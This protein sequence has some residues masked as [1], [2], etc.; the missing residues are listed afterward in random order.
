[1]RS[2]VALTLALVV[3]GAAPASRTTSGCFDGAVVS[4]RNGATLERFHARERGLIRGY[5]RTGPLLPGEDAVADGHGGWYVAGL[6]LAHLRGNGS[7]DRTWHSPLRRRLQL[8]TLARSGDRLFVS[9]GRRVFAVDAERGRIVWTSVEAGGKKAWSIRALVATGDAVYI[10]GSFSRIGSA[11]RHQLAA[12]SASNG[13]LLPWQAP[14]LTPYGP[15]IFPAVDA[16]AAGGG[17]LYFAGASGFRGVG[18]T[19]RPDGV[20]AVRLSDGGLT[21]FQPRPTVEPLSLAVAGRNVL[22]GSQETGGG[23]YDTRTGRLRPKIGYVGGA[24]AIAVRGSY[25]YVGGNFRSTVGVHNLVAVNLR[26]G[27]LRLHWFPYPARENGLATIVLSGD[28]AFLGGQFCA[29]L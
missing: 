4:L 28:K 27:D 20:A 19:P 14:A 26:T 5:V 2:L 7:L 17:R 25:A 18:G 9:D 29:S 15:T 10:G 12:L 13:R 1:M 16:L 11:P 6:G 3:I 22:I 23:V 21:S 8:W 24:A